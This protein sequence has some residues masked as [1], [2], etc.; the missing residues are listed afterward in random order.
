M[1]IVPVNMHKGKQGQVH[2][3]TLVVTWFGR[4]GGGKPV[5]VASLYLV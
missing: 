5:F 3:N 2:I 4:W 1:N